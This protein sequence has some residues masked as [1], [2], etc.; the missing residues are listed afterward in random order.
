MT[1]RLLDSDPVNGIDTWHEYNPETKET[2]LIYVPTHDVS[3][4]LDILKAK[5]NDAQASRDGIKNEWWHYAHIPNSLLLKCQIEEGIDTNDTKA[6]LRKVNSPEYK[7]LKA[8]ALK[9]E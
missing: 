7:Y 9:H 3:D 8:T 2:T 1:R 4:T 5:A 6:L